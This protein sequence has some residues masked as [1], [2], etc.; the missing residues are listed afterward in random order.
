VLKGKLAAGMKSSVLRNSLVVFQFIISIGLIV[1]TIVIYRQLNYIRNKEVGF[2]RSQVLVVH[3]TWDLGPDGAQTFRKELLAL[4]GISD[5]TITANLPTVG[6]GRY[7]TP[8]WFRE[9]T[10]RTGSIM[11]TLWVDDHYI[12]TLGMKIVKGRNF[13]LARFPTD[14][15]GIIINEAA[16][17]LLG[18]NDPLNMQLWRQTDEKIEPAAFHVIGVVK[19]FNYN[20]MHDEI[21]PLVLNVNMPNDQNFGAVTAR[22][23]TNDV[24]GLVRQ[25]EAKFH[26]IK[27]GIPF[28]YTFMDNDFNILYHTEQ[29]RGQIFITFAIFAI[30]IACLG[31]FG[32]VTYAAEQRTKEIRIRKIL[33]AP[34][35]GIVSL[36]SK[37]FAMLIGLAALIAFPLAGW[38]MNTW[39][40]SFAYRTGISWWIFPVAGLTA[41]AIALLTVSVQTIR[42][43]TANPIESLRSE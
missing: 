37:D 27:Q 20:S 12:P 26:A 5:A 40:Q 42:A 4:G 33:G 3:G 2:N 15:T 21:H 7:A 43:A 24:F 34:V 31:L 39:L 41:L 18:R 32:L 25:V 10:M 22:I 11:T 19:D 35:A 14:S 6:G 29:Q 23:Q 17:R 13:D 8:G 9:P 30:F 38:F 28:D 16:A 1:C 36:L